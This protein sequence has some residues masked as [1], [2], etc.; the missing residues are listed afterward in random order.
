MLKQWTTRDSLLTQGYE[1]MPDGENITQKVKFDA[2]GIYELQAQTFGKY[3]NAEVTFQSNTIE[4]IQDTHGP[5]IL[6]MVSPENGQLTYITRNNMHLRFNEELNG[7]ALSKSANFR[8]EGG[9]NNVVL[10]EGRPYPDV[11]VQLNGNS[12]QTEAIYDLSNS[13]CAF[14]MWFYRQG[15]G[16][17]ISMGTENNLLSLSTH[18]D[19]KLRARV[20]GE[21]AVFETGKTLPKDTWMY[22]A[23]N[24]KRKTAADQDNTI[25]M[26]YATA[27]DKTPVYVGKNMPAND[28]DGHGKLYVGGDGMTGMVG[29]LS[30]WNNGVSADDLYLSR[31]NNRAAYTPGL[32]GYWTMDE[33]HG[34]Q[35]TDR[36]RSRNMQMPTESWYINNE[37]R[38]A[39]LSGKADSPL[40]VDISTF[41]P[42]KTDNFAYEM[43][44][45]GNE[46]D[47]DSLATLMSVDNG[48]SKVVEVSDTTYLEIPIINKKAK[49]YSRFE[50]DVTLRTDVGFDEG[51]LILRQDEN[52][53]T[54]RYD[55]EDGQFNGKMTLPETS[56]VTKVTL[57]EKKYLD[58]NWHHLA[59]NVRRGTSAIVYI[60]GQAVKVLP[61]ASVPGISS[62]YLTVGGTLQIDNT[63]TNCFKGDVDE[64]RIWNAALDGQ[65]ISDRMYERMDNSYPGL[66]GYFPMEDIHRTDQGNVITEFSLDNFGEKGSRLKIVKDSIVV[67]NVK[68]PT[69][70]Q[71][72]NAPALKPGSTNLLLDDTQYDFTASA[73][74]IYFSFPEG[75]LPLMDGNDFVATIS[76]IKDEY[77]NN[78]EAVQWRFHTNFA[79]VDWGSSTG[80][81]E[82]EFVKPWTEEMDIDIS[83][84]NN[85]GTPQSFELSGMP[86]WMKVDRTVGTINGDWGYVT[87]HL[88]TDV[89]VGR[90]TEYIYL[91]DHLGIRRVL[92]F[93][94][95]VTG[96]EPDWTVDTDFYESNMTLTGQIYIDDKIC[97]NTD[98]KIA[99]FD[100]LGLCRGVASPKYVRTRDAYYVDM[101]IYGGASTE[102]SDGTSEL[103]F[104]VY[105]AST[106]TI[107]PLVGVLIPNKS[108]A[109][110]M[111]YTPDVNY[112]SYDAPVV[113]DVANALQQKISLAKGWTWMSIYVEPLIEMLEWQ[114]P[115]DKNILMRFKNIKSQVD[116]FANVDKDGKLGGNLEKMEPGK[117]YKIQLS[118]RTDFDLIG[119]ALKVKDLPQTMH[120]GYNW[121][122]TLS[123]SVMSVD[124]AFAE[125][126]PEPGDRVKSRTAF[127]EFSNKG[128]WEGTLESIVPGQGYIYRSKATKEK[129]FH[130]PSGKAATA[131][132]RAAVNSSLFTLH[133]SLSHFTPVDP[134]LYPD[135]LNIIAVV[136]KDGQERDDAEIGAFIDGECRG[137]IGCNKGL[138]FLTVMG[139]SEDDS[140]KKMELRVWVDGEEYMVDNARPFISDAAYGTLDEPYV[141][142]IDATAIRAVDGSYADNDADWYTLQGFKIGRKPTQPGVYIHHGQKV[143]IKRMK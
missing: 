86:S 63:I 119:M 120:P 123:S 104:K 35:I 57:S 1:M 18:D 94:L 2:D 17:I 136:K 19:G 84:F 29:R 107:H 58:G 23:L 95:K 89:P 54:V 140:Q 30:I 106:G 36:A 3:G 102:Q 124:E 111:M 28:L 43:W 141:L 96:D 79:S 10:D 71:A 135:N 9:L 42:T 46:A 66:V 133:S 13:D 8:I 74:E 130:Y 25:T 48:T 73:D 55:Y 92:K 99:A 134:Y 16:T 32:V 27:N 121:I 7:N 108:Y 116:G 101:V 70:T 4:I 62:Q 90:H 22:M 81:Y 132:A 72:A 103:T 91:T 31:Q 114:L 100:N 117:M 85:T 69:I 56:N 115:R 34:T 49:L 45:R 138:Y 131:Q 143:T 38:A 6:G 15:D 26:L 113:L 53:K 51:K 47:N 109:L 125:L 76:Y 110:S 64:V 97:E 67:D 60:D 61:E 77:G 50:S 20:G 142:D 59:L 37:N 128:Y 98:T 137:A 14:D 83:I 39:H 33:G 118:T 126:A 139:S 88:G 12:I 44:F 24:Y 40:K 78:S 93:N 52:K 11:A 82:R 122:G 65:L 129:T 87:F 75:A 105:D 80:D 68:V 112:G 127:A 5:K 41:Q 21:D